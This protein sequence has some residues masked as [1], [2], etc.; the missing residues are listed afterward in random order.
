[1]TIG[2]F[3]VCFLFFGPKSRT[4]QSDSVS[5]IPVHPTLEKSLSEDTEVFNNHY[6]AFEFKQKDFRDYPM[7]LHCEQCKHLNVLKQPLQTCVSSLCGF[8][9]SAAFG[10]CW[11]IHMQKHMIKVKSCTASYFQEELSLQGVLRIT[12]A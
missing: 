11:S 8:S 10:F 9:P 12:I 4:L 1:M 2:C 7:S 5:Q 6:I 3:D